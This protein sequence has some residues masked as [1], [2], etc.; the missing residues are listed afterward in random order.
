MLLKEDCP[1]RILVADDHPIVRCGLR[2]ILGGFSDMA[3]AGEAADAQETL[4]AVR[5][6]GDGAVLLL[7]L[8]MP[9]TDGLDLLERI[10]LERPE[11]PVL[12][13]TIAPEDQFAVRALRAG[14]AGYL[15]KGSSPDE[16]VLAIR[17]V[18]SGGRYVSASLAERL[19]RDL[20]K[21]ASRSGHER[22]SDREYQIF[23]NLATGKSTRAISEELAL[24]VK[25]V[26]TY[27]TRVFEKLGVRNNAELAAYAVR[28][29]LTD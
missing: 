5:S 20:T 27:R 19:A 28:H 13:L 18:S 3:I 16:L 21:G 22:L 26:S 14:A 15:V 7:D 25:T 12:V 9:G 8:S 29:H 10:R 11:L 23:R 6:V 1:I 17:K 2:H 24:S 4:A